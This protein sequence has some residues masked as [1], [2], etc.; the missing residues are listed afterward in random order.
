[1]VFDRKRTTLKLMG[2][3]NVLLPNGE[4]KYQ[5]TKREV[6]RIASEMSIPIDE[7]SHSAP[8]GQLFV[9]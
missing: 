5:Q 6:T 4:A 2:K 7:N 9:C 8:I 3:E 1:M